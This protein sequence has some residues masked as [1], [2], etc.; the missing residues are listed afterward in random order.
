[1]ARL[2][3]FFRP[4]PRRW[5]QRIIAS[6]PRRF[7]TATTSPLK[8]TAPI[9]P[10]HDSYIKIVEVGARDGLQNEKKAIPLPVKLDLIERLAKTGLSSIEAGA[11]VSPKWVPQVRPTPHPLCP[12]QRQDTDTDCRRPSR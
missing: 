5:A 9:Q 10:R 3:L 4:L 11:F 1:M 2:T 8:G 12:Q 7:A 6:A